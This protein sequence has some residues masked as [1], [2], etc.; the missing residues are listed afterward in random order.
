MEEEKLVC[1]SCGEETFRPPKD[2]PANA[3]E[4][5]Q[6][7]FHC[8]YCGVA[9]LRD[10]SVRG[11]RAQEVQTTSGHEQ[12][13]EEGQEESSAGRGVLA[14]LCMALLGV[15]AAIFLKKGL[16]G[17]GGGGS[18]TGSSPGSSG[19]GPKFPWNPVG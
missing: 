6:V 7:R 10:G 16:K 9:N 3:R 2:P 5:R 4:A 19:Q 8:E 1:A 15:V 17:P 11:K 14:V 13:P 12:R 18:G